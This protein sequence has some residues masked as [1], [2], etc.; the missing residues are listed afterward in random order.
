MISREV[1]CCCKAGDGIAVM[2]V[3]SMQGLKRKPQMNCDCF[4]PEK[5]KLQNI[6]FRRFFFLNTLFLLSEDICFYSVSSSADGV[7]ALL[8]PD[9]RSTVCSLAKAE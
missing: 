3:L 2:L 6:T 7:P 4:F 8:E 1:I 9:A 5:L